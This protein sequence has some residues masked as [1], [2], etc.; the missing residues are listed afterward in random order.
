VRSTRS[1][2]AMLLCSVVLAGCWSYLSPGAQQRFEVRPGAFSVTVFPLHVVRGS[3]LVHDS[4]LQDKLVAMLWEEKLADPVAGRQSIDIPVRW[5]ANQAKMAQQSAT[6]FAAKIRETGIHTDYALLAEILCN[7]DETDVVGV[8]FY[9]SD[10]EGQLASGG[11]T[12]SHWEEFK[13]IQPKDRQ[14]GYEVLARMLSKQWKR[15]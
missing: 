6:S 14:G 1:W 15:G 2:V 7:A 4:V 9:L 12:N 13:Q 3:V 8:H 11:L 10:R 5:G